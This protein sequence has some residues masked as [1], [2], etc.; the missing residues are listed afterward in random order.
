MAI[1]VVNQDFLT[2]IAAANL[3]EGLVYVAGVFTDDHE[4]S[5]QVGAT[6]GTQGGGGDASVSTAGR[7]SPF[8]NLV[9]I[10]GLSVPYQNRMGFR[11]GGIVKTPYSNIALGG[12]LDSANI[13]RIEIVRG[14]NAVLYGTGVLSG[15]VN[16]I[17]E[18]P[19]AE[20]R[21]EISVRAGNDDY[22]RTQAEI[23]GPLKIDGL[24]GLLTYRAAASS[25]SR[26]HWTDFREEKTRY[27]TA[28]LEYQP[29]RWMK[30]FLEYQ[31]GFNREA[32]IGPQW[33]YDSPDRDT[34]FRN[35]VR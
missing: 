8:A 30:V 21:T 10:R 28:Q 17:P 16:V 7:G 22:L 29:V 26:G 31:D 13:E 20:Q 24:P 33:I 14:P 35:A 27:W 32:G 5:R 3:D 4:A 18:R 15:I 12:L 11:Y 23:T 2:D 25:D 9:Y 34:E 1:Q 6:R 19:L